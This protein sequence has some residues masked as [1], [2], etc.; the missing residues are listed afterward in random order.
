MGYK[1]NFL[2]FYEE[3]LE[4]NHMPNIAQELK[5]KVPKK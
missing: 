3:L 1:F 4:C 2:I 5:G